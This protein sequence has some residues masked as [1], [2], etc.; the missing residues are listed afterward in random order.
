MNIG[1]IIGL[2]LG[3]IAIVFL[4]WAQSEVWGDTWYNKAKD[5]VIGHTQDIR[6]RIFTGN[7]Y[8]DGYGLNKTSFEYSKDTIHW[9]KGTASIRKNN[10][11]YFVQLHT[12]FNTGFAPDLYVV[13]VDK[14]VKSQSDLDSANKSI[15]YKLRKPNGASYYQFQPETK[16]KSVVI[17]C[18]RFNEWMGSAIL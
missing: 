11:G 18:K 15:L 5:A 10:R 9:A 14:E 3:G 4:Y 6:D 1:N 17:W 2:I 8:V 7:E 13:L 16:V 12:D